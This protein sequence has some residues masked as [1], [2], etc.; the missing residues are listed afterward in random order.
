MIDPMS[1]FE[2]K[3]LI[4]L[5]LFGLDISI[6]NSSV[7]MLL[8][9]LCV[10]VFFAIG[11]ANNGVVPGKLQV[12]S[13]K[14]FFFTGDIVKTNLKKKSVEIFPYMISLFIFILLGN[15]VGLFPFAFSFTSQL[16][17]TAGMATAVFIASIVLGFVNQGARYFRHFCPEGIPSYLI[18]FFILIELMSFLFRPISMGIRLFANMVAGH[19]MIKVIAGFAVS[20]AG[21]AALS[22]ASIIPVTINVFLNV[23]KLIVCLLQAYV[24][25]VLSCI[26]LSESLE[27]SGQSH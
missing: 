3:T 27:T 19:I 14:I 25:V 8:V 21:M 23:F 9:C 16:I 4:P 17:V 5:D 24:F 6:T 7:F 22:V 13:E 15:I 20:L 1:S 12:I 26:Y 18:P 2:V 11:T 10:C